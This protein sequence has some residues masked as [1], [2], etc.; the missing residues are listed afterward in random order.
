MAGM[1]NALQMRCGLGHGQMCRLPESEDLRKAHEASLHYLRED[2]CRRFH[3]TLARSNFLFDIMVHSRTDVAY[4]SGC[5]RM[6]GPRLK[7]FAPEHACY[8]EPN[9][10]Q[11]IHTMQ[12]MGPASAVAYMGY[13]AAVPPTR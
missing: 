1:R 2:L 3:I 5:G 7:W 11:P 4:K 8:A 6:K 9:A 13:E 10:R 12:V